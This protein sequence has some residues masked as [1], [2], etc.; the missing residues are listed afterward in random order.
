MKF[1]I[2]LSV[3]LFCL[4]CQTQPLANSSPSYPPH[5]W[6]TV[7]REGAPEW[8]ILPQQ[9]GAGEVILS[10]RNELGLLSN[11]AATPFEFRGRS[12]AS[13]EGFWQMMKYPEGPKDP[14]MKNPQVTW[15]YT[16]EQ[17]S[18]MTAFEAKKAGSLASANMKSLNIDWVTFDGKKINYREPAK[19]EFYK[20]ILE[21]EWS[22]LRQNPQ[23]RQVLL[24]T[25]DLRLR[26]DHQ[27]EPGAAP[28]WHY[29][30]IWMEIRSQL[31]SE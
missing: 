13:I 1:L 28:A 25:G 17:V 2:Y 3:S 29:H 30:E 14:R 27:E 19:G 20:L 26:P 31:Q 21:A 10:K 4:A 8:E 22:K 23:V 9:A 18:Q 12:Y 7:P 16:R 5:W 6:S 15:T 24:S 11:F